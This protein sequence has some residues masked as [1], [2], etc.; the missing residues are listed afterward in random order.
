[1]STIKRFIKNYK[2]S[3]PLAALILV[4]VVFILTRGEEEV[5]AE[6]I[7][8]AKTTVAQEVSVT[9][10][11]IPAQEVSLAVQ[12]GGKVSAIPVKVGQK[13]STG[14]TLLRVD[15]ADLHVRLARQQASLEK[16]KLA[17]SK[18][19]PG[20][21]NATDDLNKAFEDG[22]NTIA[23]M[24]L[25]AP[26]IVTGLNDMLFN[27]RQ[28][29]YLVNDQQVRSVGGQTAI[30]Y[31]NE[32]IRKYNLAKDRY[33]ATLKKYKA[34]TRASSP[35]VIEALINETYETTRLLADAVKDVRN[36]VDFLEDRMDAPFPTQL[37]ADQANLTDYTEETN[38]HLSDLLAIRNTIEDS[39]DAITDESSDTESSRID[40]RQAELDIQDTAVQIRNRTITSPMNG[41]ITDISA[42]VGENISP[43]TPVISAISNGQFE[44]EANIP[45]ADMAKVRLGALT[46]VTLDAYGSDVMFT[47]KV[48]SIA[49]AETLV[50]GVATYKT[51]FQFVENDE[52]VKSGMT[53]SL[54]ITGERK[55]DVIAIPQRSVI[56]KN[57]KKYVQV[58]ENGKIV[59]KTVETGLRGSDGSIE[60]IS[61]LVEGESVVVFNEEK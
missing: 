51:R 15:S 45:E 13:V 50:D 42:K 12:A 46:E 9:G 38:G 1:M 8:A 29:E 21:G 36:V 60:I 48:V 47:A 17:L 14:Q 22:Y 2:F 41:I 40:I 10:R 20:A 49:P 58:L 53:A 59:E 44:I 55:D 52:R 43:G 16:A 23:D 5:K 19:I 18:Q 57:D 26:S 34:T 56:T 39:R 6:T 32:A 33:D 4:G 54:I 30:D 28:S 7:L 24:F 37:A 61:G 25:D 31:K 27:W 3:I 11:V 35:D